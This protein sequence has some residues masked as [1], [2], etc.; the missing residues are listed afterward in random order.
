MDT[1]SSMIIIPILVRISFL[2][3]PYPSSLPPFTSPITVVIVSV[4][5]VV[6]PVAI[7]VVGVAVLTWP[8]GV[9]A[10]VRVGTVQAVWYASMAGSLSCVANSE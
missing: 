9:V 7:V 10:D 8:F 2:P 4:S 3:S 6:V 1:Y 5:L